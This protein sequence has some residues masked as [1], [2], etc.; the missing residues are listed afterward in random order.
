MPKKPLHLTAKYKM[1]HQH[2]ATKMA[3]SA[4]SILRIE[5]VP[6][7]M[8]DYADGCLCRIQFITGEFIML[9]DEF[10]KVVA[11]WEAEMASWE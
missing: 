2:F 4:H 9:K 10:E 8:S 7:E 6:P 5:E 3:V 11:A 1:D